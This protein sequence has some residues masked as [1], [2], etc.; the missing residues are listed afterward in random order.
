MDPEEPDPPIIPGGIPL[1]CG[2]Y[3]FPISSYNEVREDV[4]GRSN[5][6]G[7]LLYCTPATVHARFPVVMVRGVEVSRCNDEEAHHGS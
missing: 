2:C 3:V 7:C 5:L 4:F 1:P 6:E